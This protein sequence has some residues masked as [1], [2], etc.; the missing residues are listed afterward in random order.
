MLRC[1]EIKFTFYLLCCC[2]V[3]DPNGQQYKY[4]QQWERQHCKVS[5]DHN[6][7]LYH[8]SKLSNTNYHLSLSKLDYFMRELISIR[9]SYLVL[10]FMIELVGESC[11][12]VS[13]FFAHWN[14]YFFT[15]SI[16]GGDT[17]ES[18]HHHQAVHRHHVG[19]HAL[20]LASVS[21]C[22]VALA[23]LQSTQGMVTTSLRPLAPTLQLI[24]PAPI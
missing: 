6:K 24:T 12:V 5:R 21:H 17:T 2:C 16:V 11:Q 3:V 15:L 10:R 9:L 14:W 19:E 13:N 7:N 4:L 23:T 1:Q 20:L 22:I 18:Q 8:L